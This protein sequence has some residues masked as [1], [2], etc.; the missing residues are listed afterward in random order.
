MRYVFVSKAIFGKHVLARRKCEVIALWYARRYP[1][2]V[3]MEQLQL[4]IRELSREANLTVNLTL[5]QWQF[6]W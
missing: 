6:P 4:F 3:H 2:F 5:P 1:F